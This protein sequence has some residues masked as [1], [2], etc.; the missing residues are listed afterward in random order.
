MGLQLGFLT[1]TDP[2]RT[3][4]SILGVDYRDVV[5]FADFQDGGKYRCDFWMTGT[6]WLI[7]PDLLVTAGHAVY[8]KVY[9][10]GAATQIK[11]YIGYNGVESVPKQEGTPGVQPRYGSKVATTASWIEDSD[12][13][14]RDVAFIQVHKDFTGYLNVFKFTETILL[15][16]LRLGIVGYPGEKDFKTE[17]GAQMYEMFDATHC[18]LDQHPRHMFSYKISTYGGQ[19]GAPILSESAG[20]LISIGT[21]CYGAGNGESTNSGNAIGGDWG[22]DYDSF[23]SLFGQHRSTLLDPPVRGSQP[24]IPSPHPDVGRRT[25]WTP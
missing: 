3:A 20:S 19:S 13:R 6:G 22:N 7:R 2:N 17:K 4:E 21:H 12:A 9:G 24:P 16:T 10:Y 5:N 14:P 25:S 23:I 18:D 11:C 15:A 8:D 1:G